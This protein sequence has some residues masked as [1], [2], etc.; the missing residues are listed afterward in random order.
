MSTGQMDYPGTAKNY[1]R[2]WDQ[3]NRRFAMAWRNSSQIG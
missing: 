1:V 2:R 3:D